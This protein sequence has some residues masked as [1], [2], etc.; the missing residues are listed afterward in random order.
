MKFKK[1]VEEQKWD[2]P[3]GKRSV[4]EHPMALQHLWGILQYYL[5]SSLHWLSRIKKKKAVV[6][7]L[8]HHNLITEEVRYYWWE[9]SLLAGLF[10][11]DHEIYKAKAWGKVSVLCL[12]RQWRNSKI[13]Q[14]F[15]TTFEKI[16][17]SLFGREKQSKGGYFFIAR[18]KSGFP[19]CESVFPADQ[20]LP[21]QGL[22]APFMQQILLVSVKDW[23]VAAQAEVQGW[24]KD[25]IC[26]WF[27]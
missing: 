26:Y 11:A 14:M 9:K 3:S 21:L 7:C 25:R 18:D 2:S 19:N 16:T 6:T 5:Q 23:S 17:F 15:Q 1:S 12:P 24:V 4:V 27:V 22:S 10:L 20:S 8:V 13:R